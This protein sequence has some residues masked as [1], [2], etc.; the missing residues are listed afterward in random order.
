MSKERFLGLALKLSQCEKQEYTTLLDQSLSIITG[1][2]VDCCGEV[3]WGNPLD[4]H[5]SAD[6]LPSIDLAIPCYV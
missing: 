6:D 4:V 5:L 3:H 2:R 1:Y